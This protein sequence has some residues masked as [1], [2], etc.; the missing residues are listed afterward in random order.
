MAMQTMGSS[1]TTRI[2]A[3]SRPLF[4][5]PGTWV[6]RINSPSG[7]NSAEGA[8]GCLPANVN[9]PA[10]ATRRLG[11]ALNKVKADLHAQGEFIQASPTRGIE[12]KI[13]PGAGLENRS[14]AR[15]ALRPFA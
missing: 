5:R 15:L 8:E 4:A 1:S 3:I 10:F 7:H 13:A 11:C 6:A 12:C 14:P 9:M 2:R